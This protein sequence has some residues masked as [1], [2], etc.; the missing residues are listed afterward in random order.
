LRF[1][2]ASIAFGYLYAILIYRSPVR[3]GLFIAASIAV[4]IV[5]NGFR[6]LGIVYLGYLL[7]S[8]EAAATDHVLYGW[9]FFSI[10][11]LILIALGLPFRQDEFPYR[12]PN[13]SPGRQVGRQVGRQ[14]GRLPF[15][16]S[17]MV[18]AA[19][20][21]V[22]MAGI[23]PLVAQVLSRAAATVPSIALAIDPGPGCISAPEAGADPAHPQVRA[24]RLTC[25]PYVMD[26]AWEPFSP[27]V[28]AASVMSERRRLTLEAE[29]ESLQENWAQ[30]T[31]GAPSTWR[32]M[33]SND[34]VFA[35][36]V[37]IWVDGK[38]VRPGLHMR[39]RMALNSLV[40]GSHAP[41]VA[42]ITPVVDWDKLSRD[43]RLAVEQGVGEFL[44][45]YPQVTQQIGAVSAIR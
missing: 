41:I 39:L 31:D 11:I 16:M 13:P 23:G 25:G 17:G 5:A 27:R 28:T 12:K 29:T 19:I 21:L 42:T 14:L 34:P 43:E 18:L 4:P 6:G 24:Q 3:R 36:A 37:S 1:L 8:A 45:R 10:V 38:P 33:R 32:V 40:G 22:L 26:L 7:G 20:A 9:I 15:Q 2:I 44:S 30:T 35:T